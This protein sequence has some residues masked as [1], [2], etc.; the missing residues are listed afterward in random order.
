ML[1][2]ALLL[3]GLAPGL[4]AANPVDCGG[5]SVSYAE[6]VAELR[7]SKDAL[8]RR[9]RGSGPVEVIP[10]SLCPDIIER[11]RREPPI[12]VIVD[13]LQGR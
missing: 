3:V 8:P 12:Q 11:P 1:R 10:H 5:N 4:A 13:P 2:A 9:S 6:V 7:P